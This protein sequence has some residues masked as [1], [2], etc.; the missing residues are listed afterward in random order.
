MHWLEL[1]GAV[2]SILGVWLTARRH[3]LCWPLGLASVVVYAWVFIDARL[4]SDVLLQGAFAVFI[5]YGWVR[6]LQHLGDDGR[7]VIAPLAQRR[8]RMHLLIG[9]AGAVL[10]GASMHY[11][12][13][14]ALPWLD[15]ALAA[16]SL[17]A[18]FWQ[19]RRHIAAWWLWI[20]VDLIYIGQYI[21]K[22]LIITSVLYGV[23]VV[24]AV[25]GLRAWQHAATAA[26]TTPFEKT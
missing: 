3:M 9:A 13:N 1:T 24:L 16:F 5:I 22:G 15:A 20:A 7:V 23:F 19:A 10:L 6:W 26:H 21:I 2:L 8:M 14:A 25:M 11:G 12:T 18:Q 4:Y 17:V